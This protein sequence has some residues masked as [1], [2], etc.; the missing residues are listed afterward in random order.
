MDYFFFINLLCRTDLLEV[1]AFLHI[2]YFRLSR[3]RITFFLVTLCAC[4]TVNW[5]A[6]LR[7]RLFIDRVS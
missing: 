5:H 2:N 4:A 3:M 6:Q 7:A 1:G